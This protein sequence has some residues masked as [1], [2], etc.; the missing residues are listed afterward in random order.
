[1]SLSDEVREYYRRVEPFLDAELAD[2]GDESFWEWAASEPAGCRVLE[3][4]AGTGRA[5]RFLARTAGRVVAFDLAPQLV[6]L[7]RR[8]MAP[9]ARVSLFAGDLRCPGVAADFDLVVAVDD[10][11]AHLLGD[12]ERD[13]GLQAMTAR[14]ASGGRLI[15]DAAWMSPHGRRLAKRPEGLVLERFRGGGADHLRVREEIHCGRGRICDTALE[16][17]RDGETLATAAY[18]SRLWS[19]AEIR[20]RSRA[21]GLVLTHLWG[22]YD[23]RPWHRQTS[24]RLLVEARRR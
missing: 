13:A 10:P 4:G 21:A 2:R 14:L 20:Q 15:L 16:Y 3:V 18:R 22:A 7:A 5:T 8:R 17:A 19:L 24:P 11:F 6:V 23:R 9:Q 1:M 12:E